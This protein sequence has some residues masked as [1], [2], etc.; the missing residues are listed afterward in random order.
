MSSTQT[1]ITMTLHYFKSELQWLFP[2]AFWI[3]L[4]LEGV[5]KDRFRCS[6]SRSGEIEIYSGMAACEL[7]SVALSRKEGEPTT[8]S[9]TTSAW[10]ACSA[11]NQLRDSFQMF[12]VSKS[13]SKFTP[14][15][16]EMRV[17]QK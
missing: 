13:S 14:G 5:T 6:G 17:W 3:L 12:G 9:A 8:A 2:F 16:S 4:F 11:E 10:I 1:K 7:S 15:P